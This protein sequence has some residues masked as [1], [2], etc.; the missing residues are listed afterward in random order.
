[1]SLAA[2]PHILFSYFTLFQYVWPQRILS[3]IVHLPPLPTLIPGVQLYFSLSLSLFL[4]LML[5]FFLF[6]LCLFSVLPF[7]YQVSIVPI[8]P[9]FTHT[10][11]YTLVSFS[12][13]GDSVTDSLLNLH[14]LYMCE[15][16]CA[17]ALPLFDCFIVPVYLRHHNFNFA[18]L[19]RSNN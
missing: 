14:Y 7:L 11:L 3:I 4:P 15:N 6:P 17:K 13:C 10:Y 1:M 19:L 9:S 12:L 8:V 16:V 2:K 18:E 5:F